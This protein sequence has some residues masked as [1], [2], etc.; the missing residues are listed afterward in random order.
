MTDEDQAAPDGPAFRL[1][2]RSHVRI[3][4]HQ[5]RAELGSIFSAARSNNKRHGVTG[6]LLVVD[7]FFV[8]ALEGDETTVR[9][10][11]ETIRHDPRH[12]R[13]VVLEETTVP[14]RVFGRW[15]MARVTDDDEP[16]IPLIMNRDKGGA[17]PAASRPTT[18]EQDALLESMRAHAHGDTQPA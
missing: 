6:A 3:A 13:V 8:Q 10:L 7:D 16:D 12:E 2:Y 5:R 9:S 14:T 11:Y 4:G 18:P 15:S 1:L 17:S